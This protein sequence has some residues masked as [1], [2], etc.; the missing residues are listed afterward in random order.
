MRHVIGSAVVALAL[1]GWAGPAFADQP[2]ALETVTSSDQVVLVSAP[3]L[4]STKGTLRTYQ[5]SAGRWTQ[6]G[7][8]T[9]V[10]LGIHGLVAGN[11]RIQSTGKTPM[12]RYRLTSA[13]GRQPDPGSHLP[14]VRVDH[15]DAWTYDPRVPATYNLFQSAPRP[16]ASYGRFVE[17]LWQM[18]PQYDYVV[19]TD[20][21][22]PPG[23]IVRTAD[24]INR[25]SQ[26]ANTRRGGGIFLH[27]SKGVPTAGC[28]SMPKVRMRELVT[29]LKPASNPIVVIGLERQLTK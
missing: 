29:W 1:S 6:I 11:Q 26:P 9:P 23:P 18:G 10:F 17:H 8:P 27:V 5:R 14:Y 4:T 13:F 21:N 25:A 7:R 24:G 16:W 2:A 22:A 15:D 3:A 20:F 28:I 19:A 12:G